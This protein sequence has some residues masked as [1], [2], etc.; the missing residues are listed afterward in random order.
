M[1]GYRSGKPLLVEFNLEMRISDLHELPRGNLVPAIRT[2][3]SG[4][5]RSLGWEFWGLVLRSMLHTQRIAFAPHQAIYV[6]VEQ[7]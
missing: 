3:A 2:E 5:V 7:Q 1:Y 4:K 6:G